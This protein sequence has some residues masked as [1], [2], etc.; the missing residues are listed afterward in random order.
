MRNHPLSNAVL[1]PILMGF[2]LRSSNDTYA[3]PRWGFIQ[4][5]PVL[6]AQ[7]LRTHQLSQRFGLD[8]AKVKVTRLRTS[9]YPATPSL[10]EQDCAEEVELI[11]SNGTVQLTYT[12]AGGKVTAESAKWTLAEL[13]EMLSEKGRV[14]YNGF[15]PRKWCLIAASGKASEIMKDICLAINPG[16]LPWNK[17]P[18][19]NDGA[20]V[21]QEL[22]SFLTWS[23]PNAA[24]SSQS[25]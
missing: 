1:G 15:W 24:E 6:I 5:T 2:P 18:D 23:A 8:K 21:I 19:Y 14:S 13:A 22:A 25:N 3:A 7:V 9:L 12:P 17:I 4:W 16:N 10:T 20:G 11:C